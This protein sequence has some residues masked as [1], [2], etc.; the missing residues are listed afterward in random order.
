MLGTDVDHKVLLSENNVFLVSD[1]SVRVQIIFFGDIGILLVLHVQR[2]GVHVIILA[3]R[4]TDPVFAQEE[5]PH[6]RIVQKTDTEEVEHF[7]FFDFCSFPEIT[8]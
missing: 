1:C 5:T 4:I 8:Y 2:I 7:A 3:Q 6:V